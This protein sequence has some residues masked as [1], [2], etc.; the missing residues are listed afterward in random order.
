MIDQ[1]AIGRCLAELR[2]YFRITQDDLAER[3]CVSRQAVSRWETGASVPEVGQLLALS[4]LYGITVDEILRGDPG[5]IGKHCIL[6]ERGERRSRAI[7]VIGAGRWGSFLAWYLDRIGHGVTLV[8]R[9]GSA[10][11]EALAAQRRN[12]Y[13]ALPDTIRL[14]TDIGC[15]GMADFIVVS[16]PSQKL[17]EVAA[18]L[19]LLPLKHKTI[20]L[21]MKGIEADTGRRLSQVMTDTIDHTNQVA[22]WVGPGH[23]ED[24]ICGIPNC[25]VIDAASEMVKHEIIRAFASDLIRFYYGRDLIGSEIGAAAKNVIG[26][27]AG[28][29][30]GLGLTTLKG[31]LMARGTQE[32][33]R[34]I[35]AMGGEAASAYGL[36]HL[37]DYE[38]TLFSPHSHNRAYGEAVVRG[39]PYDKLAEGRA[40]ARALRNLGKSHGVELPIC[41][42]VYRILYESEDPRNALDGLFARSLKDEF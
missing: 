31:A 3:L 11:F 25:M 39:M 34:L 14:T 27:A 9:E 38:A 5:A 15:A 12:E 10:N 16:V 26:I 1:K 4:E 29:L 6:P 22:V 20:V 40:T 41:S 33:S 2:R 23:V 28:M 35:R 7:A 36:C 8:G 42:T 17:R 32:I 13:V 30:D 37:G 24:Y 18:Q 21:C 19:A